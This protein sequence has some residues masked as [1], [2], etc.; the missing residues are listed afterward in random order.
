MIL[1]LIGVSMNFKNI[2]EMLFGF[3]APTWYRWKKENRKIVTLVE[4]YFDEEVLEEF[5]TTGK[6]KKF[7]DYKNLSN[8]EETLNKSLNSK[9]FKTDYQS[10]YIFIRFLKSI[11]EKLDLDYISHG[12]IHE[13]FKYKNFQK[14]HEHVFEFLNKNNFLEYYL[15]QFSNKHLEIF[16]EIDKAIDGTG[17]VHPAYEDEFNNIWADYRF[18]LTS[19][20]EGYSNL[21]IFLSSLDA[22][23]LYYFLATMEN[24]Y[25]NDFEKQYET[26]P[27]I[28]EEIKSFMYNTDIL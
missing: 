13:T 7:E 14:I 17:I 18:K 25:K 12:T 11:D 21:I 4:E 8:I 27:K 9:M 24:R 23:E 10:L 3:S 2:I 15:E 19:R 16:N 6:I 28:K 20:S 22:I 5:L 26:L 1:I